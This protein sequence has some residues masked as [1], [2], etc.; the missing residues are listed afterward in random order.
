MNIWNVQPWPHSKPAG[1]NQPPARGTGG[2]TMVEIAL[3]L[4]I[5]AFALVAIIGVMPSGLKVQRENREDTI[6]NQDGAYL[7]EAIRSG[8]RGVD[9]L[10]N[11]VETVSIKRGALNEITFTNTTGSTGGLLRLTNAQ[12]IVSLLSTPK[13]ERLA[14]GTF[15]QTTVTAIMRSISGGALEKS[16]NMQDF[17]FRYQVT[18]EVTPYAKDWLTLKLTPQEAA[19]LGRQAMRN[20][21]L[22]QNLYEVRLTLRWPLI[23]KGSSYNVGRYRRTMRTLV[24]GELLPIYTNSAPYLYLFEP[25]TFISAH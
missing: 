18:C 16:R 20:I 2:F 8:S 10:T 7:L 21:N 1:E 6:I 15:R 4:G 14:N 22:A 9:E 3:S 23:P 19:T 25:Y 12:H 11:Y 13:I 17:A 24:S 5:V